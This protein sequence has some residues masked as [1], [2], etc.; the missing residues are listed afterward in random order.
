MIKRKGRL[1]MILRAES[2]LLVTISLCHYAHTK[3]IF[4]Y[5]SARYFA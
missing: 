1:V 4:V 5:P 2:C 3:I